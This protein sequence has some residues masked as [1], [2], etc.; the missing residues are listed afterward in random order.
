M[1]RD[2]AGQATANLLA[3]PVAQAAV[4]LLGH[5]LRCGPV[6]LRLTE[7]EAYD[8]EDDPASH[9]WR[10]RTPRNAVMFGPA[11]YAYV[12]R[13][14]GIH[15]CLNVVTGVEGRACAVLLRAGEVVEGAVDAA[16]RRPAA[17]REVDLARG[18]GRLT[19]ALGVVAAH[20]RADLLDPVSPLRLLPSDRPVTPARTGPRVG[21]SRAAERAW[22][23]WLPDEPSVSDYSRSPRARCR[24]PG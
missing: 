24:P 1:S 21:V 18:P 5:R 2:L 13:S 12:Y 23:F 19:A 20:H 9:A 8:G 3:V 10:G 11:G 6:L 7:V 17:R 14:Y 4:A 22:R 15:L 16:R